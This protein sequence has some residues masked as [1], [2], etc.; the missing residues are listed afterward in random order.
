MYLVGIYLW[1]FRVVY[2]YF[3][4]VHL[5]SLRVLAFMANNDRT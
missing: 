3:S 5:V 4:S 1:M 2:I